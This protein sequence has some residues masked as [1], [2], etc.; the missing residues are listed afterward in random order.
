MIKHYEANDNE[1]ELLSYWKNLLKNDS[2][3]EFKTYVQLR[4][5]ND[6]HNNSNK[7]GLVII[8]VCDTN[9]KQRLRAYMDY[10]KQQWTEEFEQAFN[11]KVDQS[12]KQ[13]IS[14]KKS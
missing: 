9:A 2:D 4:K 1:E 13:V 12:I 6:T 14:V 8:R 10:I 3:I 11:T 5:N 7:F